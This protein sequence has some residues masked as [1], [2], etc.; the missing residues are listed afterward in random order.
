MNYCEKNAHL[1]QQM[2]DGELDQKQRLA[3]FRH[4]EQCPGCRDYYQQLLA[5]RQAL[6]EEPVS[7]PASLRKNIM[8]A[9]R[10]TPQQA[11]PEEQ[12]SQPEKQ[13]PAQPVFPP[14]RRKTPV[15]RWALSAACL[16]LVF[17]AMWW[18]YSGQPAFEGAKEGYDGQAGVA[19]FSNN[20]E[21]GSVEQADQQS[22]NPVQQTKGL[23]S[24]EDYAGSHLTLVLA[25]PVEEDWLEQYAVPA[26]EEEISLLP[27]EAEDYGYYLLTQE[28]QSQLPTLLEEET[29]G[30]TLLT[31]AAAEGEEAQVALAVPL[32]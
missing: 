12:A 9:V 29:L 2:L 1:L 30:Y 5:I 11:A 15:L 10:Q 21:N 28:G 22:G 23:F 4:M 25:Q 13:Q 24:L 18:A 8:D 6:T 14:R 31:E 16:T 26:Q 3:L 32:N 7:A 19:N 17:V 20:Q 27:E